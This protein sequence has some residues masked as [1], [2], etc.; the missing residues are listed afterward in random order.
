M[1][2]N[3]RDYE[4]ENDGQPHGDYI[5]AGKHIAQVVDHELGTTSGGFGQ[6]IVTFEDRS[7]AT[8]KAFL[9]YE[10]RAAFQLSTLLTAVNWHEELDLDRVGEVKR[11]IYEKDVE[12]VVVEESYQGKET[13]KVKYINAVKHPANGPKPASE[14]RTKHTTSSRGWAPTPD[15]ADE[16][17]VAPSDDEPIPF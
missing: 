14:Q 9:I 4:K 15:D 6:M 1:R 13:L 7:G 11:A 8:R 12:I 17:P 3:P 16:R 10:G 2:Y 5:P